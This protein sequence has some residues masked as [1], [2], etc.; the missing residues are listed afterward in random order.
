MA[1][2]TTN[3][4]ANACGV[5]ERT[6]WRRIRSGALSS[7]LENGRTIVNIEQTNT[8]ADRQLAG[9]SAALVSHARMDSDRYAAALTTVTDACHRAEKQADRSRRTARNAVF[10]L[11]VTLPAACLLAGV[12]YFVL[13]T[14]HVTEVAAVETKAAS[15]AA[16][17]VRLADDLT[18]TRLDLSE[19]RQD[20]TETRQIAAAAHVAT[21][22]AEGHTEAVTA[23]NSRL[24]GELADMTEK[25]LAL[26][27][28]NGFSWFGRV[29]SRLETAQAKR[30][31]ERGTLPSANTP[32][33]LAGHALDGE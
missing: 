15:S 23:A 33:V 30:I 7:R 5:S 17:A 22:A 8:T 27:R 32:A 9:V 11:S 6:V 10:A 21:A 13:S 29:L 2:L 28:S 20:L 19:T 24:R 12:G 25:R 31:N 3:A 4:A 18:A 26:L 16:V 14:R 1:W